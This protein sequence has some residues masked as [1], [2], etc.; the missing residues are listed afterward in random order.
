MWNY[1]FPPLARWISAKLWHGM[2]KT[3]MQL[4]RLFHVRFN[5]A[6]HP[7]LSRL[8]AYE[9]IQ[10]QKHRHQLRALWFS[11]NSTIAS[12]ACMKHPTK[13]SHVLNLWVFLANDSASSILN[14][15][16]FMHK[17]CD[18][19]A[20][21]PFATIHVWR[22]NNYLQMAEICNIKSCK[23]PLLWFV[24]NADKSTNSYLHFLFAF[25]SWVAFWV[26]FLRIY[27]EKGDIPLFWRK[28]TSI[29]IAI[30][31]FKPPFGRGKYL[32]GVADVIYN[33]LVCK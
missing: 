27:W 8:S 20:A 21:H 1:L 22:C 11:V 2:N 25:T 30:D 32:S 17:L 14:H 23:L 24:E 18:G 28:K 4:P 29:K 6:F 3:H 31:Q 19:C 9:P 16:W 26:N 10:D 15:R 33:F 13:S 7:F 5:A 12:N